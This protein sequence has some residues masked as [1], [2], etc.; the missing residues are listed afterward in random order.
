L[1][2][3]ECNPE[4]R[5]ETVDYN[6]GMETATPIPEETPPRPGVVRR[7]WRLMLQIGGC[8]C[9]TVI[10]L[11][12][13]G[14]IV[15][16]R[17]L[18]LALMMYIPLVPVGLGTIVLDLLRRGHSLRPRFLLLGAGVVALVTGAVPMLGSRQPQPAPPRS[19]TITLLHWN[20]MSGGRFAAQPR[21][22]RA[23]EQILSRRP[24][25]IVLSEAPPD[26]WLFHSL[27]RIQRYGWR[28]VHISSEPG[29]R[30][31]YKPLVASLWPMEFSGQV[32]VRNGVAMSV[33]VTVRGRP[34]RL[35]VVDGM[36]DIPLLRTPFLDDIAAA[37]DRAAADGTRYDVVVGDFNSLGRSVGFDA[38]RSAAGGYRRASDYSGGWRATW[39]YP[40]PVFD[41]DHVLV[42]GPVV[43]TGCDIF[44]S[45]TLD[46]DHRGQFVTLA[47]PPNNETSR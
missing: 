4:A 42:H 2:W 36:S 46:T 18:V 44:S 34:L 41:I 10:A 16:D 13:V 5:G 32:P 9:V 28:T 7:A 47:L 23:A 31:W 12:L 14:Q 1:T 27:H 30:Y 17:S 33:T 11:G 15:R 25:V 3:P 24:D 22:E 37:C 35:L 26:G 38:V 39:P 19:E 20:M 43:I 8:G 6:S 29:R 21:W 40:L 45:R